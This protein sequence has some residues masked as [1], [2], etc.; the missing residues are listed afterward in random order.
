[1]GAQFFSGGGRLAAAS[2]VKKVGRGQLENGNFQQT[3]AA[4][5]RLEIL[6]SFQISTIW[7]KCNLKLCILYT[8]WFNKLIN[9]SNYTT[10]ICIVIVNVS[11]TT[12]MYIKVVI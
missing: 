10:F 3:A 6:C 9:S 12:T 5:Y 7:R 2:L 4:N 11:A 8:G 1:M